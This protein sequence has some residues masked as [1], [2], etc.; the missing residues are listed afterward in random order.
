MTARTHEGRY[1]L[2]LAAGAGRR[3]G[4]GKLTA[5]WAGEPLVRAAVRT[6]LAAPVA[7]VIVV[8]GADAAAV[9]RAL[10]P[11]AEPRLSFTHADGWTEGLG[12]SLRAGVTA[13]PRD[14]AAVVVFL[15][16]M[17]CIPS[18][19][20]GPLLD[21]VAV[22]PASV[23]RSPH[24]PAHPAAFAAALLPCLL[25]LSGD[26]GARALLRELGDRVFAIDS[27]DPGVV[28]DVDRPEDL[29]SN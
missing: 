5:P 16:D 26:S 6:A 29:A 1:A 20:A 23:I 18:S 12:A 4:G 3:F 28:F 17:P 24:G 13:L 22:A 14:A 11:L 27:D 7:G 19:L 25:A 10:A 15:A 8:T 2:V 9:T 21:A